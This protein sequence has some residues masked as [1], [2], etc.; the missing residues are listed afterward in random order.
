MSASVR[1]VALKTLLSGP[2][3]GELRRAAS[4]LPERDRGLLIELV[5]G[6]LRRRTTLDHVLAEFAR[7]R[8]LAPRTHLV[9]ILGIYQLLYL[10]RVPAHA[11]VNGSVEL[12][13]GR[14]TRGFVNAVLRAVERAARP[15]EGVEAEGR[16]ADLLRTAPGAGFLFDR[17]LFPDPKGEPVAW[18]AVQESFTEEA[19]RLFIDEFGP[20]R[21]ATLLRAANLSPVLT[22]RETAGSAAPFPSLLAGEGLRVE[23]VE[24][25]PEPMYRLVGGGDPV[26]TELFR[27]GRFTL[28]GLHAARVVPLLQPSP[29]E[30]AIDL[31]AAPGGKTAQLAERL[32]GGRVLAC[33]LDERGRHRLEGTLRRLGCENARI[34]EVAPEGPVP[35]LPNATMLLLDVPCSNSG[36]LSRRPEARQRLNPSSLAS[37]QDLQRSLLE[38][39]LDWLA[40]RPR[41]ARLVYSTCSIF[42]RENG[43][44]VR[45]ALEARPG[46]R[47]DAE[48]QS[49]PA[50]AWSDGGYAARIRRR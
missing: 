10:G 39:G 33:T 15:V 12:V 46:F 17:P 16:A 38:R 23:P 49:L 26:R 9:L 1:A 20:D 4:R 43:D 37:L 42:R 27:A 2:E 25:H 36:V 18:L 50:E 28:Q 44:L 29:G 34:V 14:R 48:I 5:R 7:A 11:A 35:E 31:C 32:A 22:L 3:E 40:E 41:D 19:A 30:T 6:V 21:G 47:V 13:R 8:R 45:A 24:G